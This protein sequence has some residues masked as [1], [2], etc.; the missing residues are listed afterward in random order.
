MDT[1]W[2]PVTG[3]AQRR[4]GRRL[5][6]AWRHEQQSIAQALAAKTHHSAP[7]RQTMAR[8]GGWERVAL[9]GQVPEHPTPQAAGAQHFP[10]DAGEDVGEAPAAGR[11]A[12]LLE[13]LPQERVQQRTVEQIVDP[14]PVVPLLHVFV[15]QMVEQLVDILAPLD[16]RVAEQVIEVPKIVCPPRA[17]RTV[18][19]APQTADQLVEVPTIISYSSLLQRTMEQTVAIPVPLGRGGRNVDL[20]GFPPGQSSTAPLLS[21]ERISEQIVKQTVGIPVSRGGLYDCRPGQS[22]SSVARSPAAWLNTEDEAFQR[23]FALFLREK[24]VQLTPGTWVREC[25][26]T[27][28]HPRRQLMARALGWTTTRVRLG[29]C[30]RIRRSARGGTARA[31][32]APTG[33]RRGSAEPGC[34]WCWWTS[35]CSCRDVVVC[36]S[37]TWLTCPWLCIAKCA[38]F[39]LMSSPLLSWRRG[40]FPWSVPVFLLLQYIDKVVVVLSVH[41]CER[42][43]SS[44]SC[45]LDMVVDMPVMFNDSPWFNVQKSAVVPQLLCR[46]CWCRFLRLWTPC[47]HAATS[48]FSSTVE[49]PQIQFSV[50]VVDIPKSSTSNRAGYDGDEW[51][52]GAF[53]AIFR[54]PPVIPELSASFS[55]PRR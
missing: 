28:A 45:S 53:C 51:F 48:L 37:S 49:V 50:R 52:F 41:C 24:Q 17:A 14:V 54:A 25:P 20:Q 6:A 7:R 4:R 10:M 43:S 40:R 27:S 23:F 11:P 35:L 55:S 47:D 3:A 26:G 19:R 2:Q 12:P 9:H 8:A 44:H 13:V 15:P 5:R 34:C 16:F 39:A 32:A 36:S 31:R 30:S 22:S 33:T 29:R 1:S 42:P 46:S 38:V 21:L 18:L